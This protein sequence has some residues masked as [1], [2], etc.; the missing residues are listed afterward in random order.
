MQAR[1]PPKEK[2]R[3]AHLSQ[4]VHAFP[5]RHRRAEQPRFAAATATQSREQQRLSEHPCGT[6]LATVPFLRAVLGQAWSCTG[7]LPRAEHTTFATQRTACRCASSA[8]SVP[9]AALSDA[10]R[11]PAPAT[12][13]RFPD[14]GDG[15]ALPASISFPC[16]SPC[17]PAPRGVPHSA[18]S[19]SLASSVCARELTARCEKAR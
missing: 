11:P 5:S 10:I 18:S 16:A 6:V 19:A 13:A 4:T 12:A 17:S 1:H 8:P 9:K 7:R 14:A 15:A 3:P 2:E